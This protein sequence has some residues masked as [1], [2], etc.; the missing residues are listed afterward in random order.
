MP[1]LNWQL[2]TKKRRSSTQGIQPGKVDLAWVTNTVTLILPGS[3][4]RIRNEAAER[5]RVLRSCY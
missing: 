1:N 4:A 2:L 3:H 5:K